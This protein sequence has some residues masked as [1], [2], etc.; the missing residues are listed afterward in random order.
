MKRELTAEEW[1]R[2]RQN[3]ENLPPEELFR[4]HQRAEQETKRQYEAFRSAFKKQICS[5]CD[6]ALATYSKKNPCLHWLLRP[7][8]V[9]K[10]GIRQVVQEL[11]YFRSATYVRWIANQEKFTSR[12]NDLTDEGNTEAFFHW[13]AVYEHIKW[14]FWCT[15]NDRKGH[16][17]TGS[18]MPHFHIEIRLNNKIFVKFNDFHIPFTDEDLFQFRCNADEDFPIDYG[19]GKYGAGMSDTMSVPP[20]LIL[21]NT[22][23]TEDVENATFHIQTKL[24][25][26]DGS[27]IEMDLVVEAMKRSKEHGKPVA[28]FLRELGLDPQIK[29]SPAD[30][31]VEKVERNNPRKKS[32]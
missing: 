31:I 4:E 7:N 22:K 32:D 11:G 9:K 6:K 15:Q 12:I 27:R 13:T 30:S 5:F 24:K 29:I 21:S 17:G 26:R 1:E 28:H 25:P 20:D 2:F 14:T 8:G 3:V 10:N 19:F 16:H 23:T 18:P